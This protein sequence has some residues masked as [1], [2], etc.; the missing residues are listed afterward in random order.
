MVWVHIVFAVFTWIA[1]LW[2]VGAAGL[3]ESE[4]ARYGKR[5]ADGAAL[6]V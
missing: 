3:L 2:S 5:R 6:K 1:V 4:F